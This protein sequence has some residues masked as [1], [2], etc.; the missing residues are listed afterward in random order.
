MRVGRRLE[1]SGPLVILCKWFLMGSNGFATREVLREMPRIYGNIT[2]KSVK[3]G[4]K[5]DW[6]GM[7][8]PGKLLENS[9]FAWG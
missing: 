5:L 1:N 7:I 6:D 9:R 2:C 4:H 3:L 8:L